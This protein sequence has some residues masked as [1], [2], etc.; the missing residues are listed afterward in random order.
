MTHFCL[1]TAEH[2]MHTKVVLIQPY[3]YWDLVTF[4]KISSLLAVS[5]LSGCDGRK[6]DPADWVCP[7]RTNRSSRAASPPVPGVLLHLCH[8]H[9]GQPWLNLSHLEG[10]PSSYSHVHFPWKF[11]LFWCLY[12]ILCDSKD[13][14]EI[15]KYEWH[16]IPGRVLFPILFFLFKCDCR[17]LPPGSNGLWPLCSHMQPSALCSYN[18][19]KT[20]CSVHK[21]I[22]SNWN[23]T[24]LDSCSIII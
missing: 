18:V 14:Y 22:I 2:L 24:C 11:S 20:L 3:S 5:S 7:Q 4:K 17:I 16:N 1:F 8:H 12:F 19:Q 6:Q 15:F 9:G 21:C 13:A 23:P 10:S